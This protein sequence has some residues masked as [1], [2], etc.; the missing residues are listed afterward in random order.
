[1]DN[2]YYH[3]YSHQCN[4]REEDHMSHLQLDPTM[5][6]PRE[7]D[8]LYHQWELEFYPRE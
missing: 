8:Q 3:L 6:H 1:M 7:E 2:L 4:T 5:S